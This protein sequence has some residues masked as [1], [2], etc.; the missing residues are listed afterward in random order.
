MK[1][2]EIYIYTKEWLIYN[3]YEIIAGQPPNGSDNIPVI[4]IK[5]N[6]YSSKGSKGSYKPDLIGMNGN[7]ILVIECKPKYDQDDEKKLLSIMFDNSRIELLF[8]E[9]HQRNIF[10]NSKYCKQFSNLNY[11]KKVIKFCLSNSSSNI[12]M[13]EIYNLKVTNKPSKSILTTPE[14]QILS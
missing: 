6:K 7:N 5:D 3:E 4:E 11:F 13:R 2:D 14:N 9:L 8:K 12:K 1:E 10:S